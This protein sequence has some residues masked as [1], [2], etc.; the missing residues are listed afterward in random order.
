M[1]LLAVRS[2]ISVAVAAALLV[3]CGPS[4]EQVARE[5]ALKNLEQAAKQME[6]AGKKAEAAAQKGGADMGA[7]LGDMMKAMGGMAGAAS[8]AAGAGSYD[9]VDF[10]KLKEVLP[11][12]LAGFEVGESSGEKNNMFGISV[13]QVKQSFKTADGSKRVSFEITDPGSLAGPFALA[14]VWLNIEVDKETS[15]GYEKTSTVG[16]RK[17]HEK[18]SKGSKHGEATLVVGNRF[19]VE[20]DAQ[21]IEMNDVKALLGKIDVSKLESM[22]AD[23]KKT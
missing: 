8:G 1:T 19:M 13:S 4:P 7:A 18:W 14:N 16:G 2:L 9:P 17:L 5:Q 11:Q 6:E 21:G 15:S 3:G 12:E 22:K 10:R 20:V 23:G